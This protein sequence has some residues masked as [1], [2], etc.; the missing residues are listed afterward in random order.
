MACCYAP[1]VNKANF[2]SWAS[3]HHHPPKSSTSS[4]SICV[5]LSLAG[6]QNVLSQH[7]YTLQQPFAP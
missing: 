7:A 3:H 2:S 6:L 5:S 4:A 1:P